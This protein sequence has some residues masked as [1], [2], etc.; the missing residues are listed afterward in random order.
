MP[1]LTLNN[2]VSLA[3]TTCSFEGVRKLGNRSNIGSPACVKHAKLRAGLM[4]SE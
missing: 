4:L 1:L 2:G 3:Q